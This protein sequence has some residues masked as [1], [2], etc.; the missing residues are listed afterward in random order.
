[1]EWP[2]IEQVDPLN[3]NGLPVAGDFDGNLANGDEVGV[4]T[5]STW[6]F[7]TNH[8]FLLDAGFGVVQQSDR[9]SDRG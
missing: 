4:F 5:G 2:M 8:D 7:D 3:I 9:L 1:M 6:Y